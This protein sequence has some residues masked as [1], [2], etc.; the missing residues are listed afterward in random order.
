MAKRAK[1]EVKNFD[2]TKWLADNDAAI[3]D[4]LEATGRSLLSEFGG[5]QDSRYDAQRWNE[6]KRP[7]VNLRAN[8][9]AGWS[10]LHKGEGPLHSIAAARKRIQGR[11]GGKK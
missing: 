11:I 4:E 3:M 2:M 10:E 9:G 8:E 5:G 7:V 6:R 1:V